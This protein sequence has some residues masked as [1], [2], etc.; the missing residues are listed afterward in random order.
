M[1]IR[2]QVLHL[3]RVLLQAAFEL[4]RGALGDE[5]AFVQAVVDGLIARG[6]C[7]LWDGEEVQ[8]KASNE[9]SDHIDILLWTGYVFRGLGS[10][11]SSCYPA[12]F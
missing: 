3:Y 6:L 8:V 4:I 10:Y 2:T 9:F 1:P 11:M 12:A 5:P 7:A